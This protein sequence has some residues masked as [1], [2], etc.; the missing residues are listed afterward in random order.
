MPRPQHCVVSVSALSREKEASAIQDPVL[1]VVD[2]CDFVEWTEHRNGGDSVAALLLIAAQ[3]VAGTP[4]RTLSD[5]VS[6]APR[7]F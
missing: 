6:R 7:R 1:S 4:L 2:Y 5:W 3:V